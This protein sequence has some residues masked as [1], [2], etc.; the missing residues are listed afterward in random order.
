MCICTR[1][2]VIIVVAIVEKTVITHHCKIA[3][4]VKLGSQHNHRYRSCFEIICSHPNLNTVHCVHSSPFHVNFVR[5][6]FKEVL[7]KLSLGLTLDFHSRRSVTLA[8]CL[9]RC[10]LDHHQMNCPCYSCPPPLT[11]LLSR[12]HGLLTDQSTPMWQS[13]FSAKFSLNQHYR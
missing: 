10:P 5:G 11:M 8:V 3:T 12:F 4:V 9:F 2:I 7:D 1:R 13:N 6:T